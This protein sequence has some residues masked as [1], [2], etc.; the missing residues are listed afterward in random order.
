MIFHSRQP[1]RILLDFL[2]SSAYDFPFKFLNRER[3][4]ESEM[5]CPRSWHK[6]PASLNM[7]SSVYSKTPL[8]L[9][10]FL[11]LFIFLPS[12][13]CLA[14]IDAANDKQHEVRQ[15]IMTSLHELG[16]KQPE[17]VLSA[18]KGYLIKHQKVSLIMKIIDNF[19]WCELIV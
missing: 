15:M 12:E 9:C 2:D 10:T 6:G 17:M 1:L 16:K 11:P 8:S 4:F 18:I 19:I 13:L 7:Q 14:L 3:N 5:S